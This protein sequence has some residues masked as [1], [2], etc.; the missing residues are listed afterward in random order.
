MGASAGDFVGWKLFD[1]DGGR[2]RFVSKIK[3]GNCRW[4][5][6]PAKLLERAIEPLWCWS[7]F[8]KSASCDAQLQLNV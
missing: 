2:L 3:L 8:V 5:E 7:N 4:E 1:L 6:A